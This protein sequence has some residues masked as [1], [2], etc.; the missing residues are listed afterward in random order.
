MYFGLMVVSSI[1]ERV[2]NTSY[3]DDSANFFDI[4]NKLEF[5]DEINKNVYKLN[6]RFEIYLRIR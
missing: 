3:L 5:H 6:K 1:N 4:L 2:F